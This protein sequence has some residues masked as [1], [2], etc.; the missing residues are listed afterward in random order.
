L[1]GVGISWLGS[2]HSFASSTWIIDNAVVIR[3][4]MNLKGVN[5]G[6]YST[7]GPKVLMSS[8]WFA[9]ILAYVE[10]HQN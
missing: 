9:N 8:L 3:N 5:I 1:G 7:I 4:T 2:V 6:K 10:M